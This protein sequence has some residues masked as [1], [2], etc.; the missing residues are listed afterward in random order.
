M[1]K[2][3]YYVVQ[4]ITKDNKKIQKIFKNREPKKLRKQAFSYFEELR[5]KY[6]VKKDKY[7][8]DK[9]DSLWYEDILYKYRTKKVFKL[10]QKSK[11]LFIDDKEFQLII[12]FGFGNC[13]S[14]EILFPIG[15]VGNSLRKVEGVLKVNLLIEYEIYSKNRMKMPKIDKN[16]YFL[17]KYLAENFM[18]YFEFYFDNKC[19]TILTIKRVFF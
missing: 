19:F 11:E 6:F 15:A 3:I 1:Q 4:A 5:D 2:Q 7:F 16:E 17:S 10:T 8:K 13:N 14:D 18:K 12:S 9:N